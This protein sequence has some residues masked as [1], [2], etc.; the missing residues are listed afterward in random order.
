MPYVTTRGDAMHGLAFAVAWF[1][2]FSIPWA[3][4]VLLPGIGT[5]SRLVGLMTLVVGMFMVL[6]SRKIRFH[7]VHALMIVFGLWLGVSYFWSM[8]P[9]QSYI[10]IK[11]YLQ[12]IVIVWIIYQLATREREILTLLSAYVLGAYVAVIGTI[13]SYVAGGGEM[14][15]R[16]AAEGYNPND[17]AYILTLAIPMAW[18]LAALERK[19]V[20]AWI[21]R[22]YPFFGLFAVFLTGSRGG[23]VVAVTIITFYGLLIYP[24]LPLR[25]RVLVPLFVVGVLAYMIPHVPMES[26]TRIMSLGGELAG[27]DLNA[28]TGIWSA[29]LDILANASMWGGG[30]MFG[31]GAGAF[32]TAVA[33]Y[34]GVEVAPHNVY[35]SI[36]VEVGAIGFILFLAI[37]LLVSWHALKMPKDERL[38]WLSVLLVW[39]IAAFVAN[40]EWRKETW[41]LF[42][43]LITHASAL[44]FAD[45][46]R[47]CQG[48]KTSML[49]T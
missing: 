44:S 43:L 47:E 14:T 28:R 3:N 7:P 17:L 37:I 31:V 11:S 5:I 19:E 18:Y 33:P 35:L 45:D 38:L 32:K 41:L 22:L 20:T 36:L 8:D 15:T 42:G 4:M 16:F 12:F 46:A 21:Y 25:Y 27:G 24:G 23:S 6:Y 40:W 2:I 48:Q 29:G 34:F 9:E 26:V 10:A 39:I 1:L 49:N 13:V 30:A